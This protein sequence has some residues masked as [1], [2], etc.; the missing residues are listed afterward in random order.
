[1]ANHPIRVLLV[2]DDEDEY[3]MARNLLSEVDTESYDVSWAADYDTGLETAERNEHDVL[4]IDY[5]LGEHNGLEL[6]RDALRIG[7]R[8]PMILLTG[9]GD[10]RVDV[11]AMRAG[12]DDYLVKDSIDSLQLERAIRYALERSR[13]EHER[14]LLEQ[15]LHHSQKMD[16]IGQL[17]GGIAH[18]FNNLLT[19]IIGYTQLGRNMVAPGTSLQTHFQ[20]IQ[21]AAQLAAD[22]TRQLLAF[23]RRQMVEQKEL[24]LND[25]I[26]DTHKMLRR[27]I[28]ENVELATV[29]EPGL[30]RVIADAGLVEQVLVNIAINARDAMPGGGKLTIETRNVYLDHEY[31]A[32]HTNV[33]PGDY[34]MLAISDTGTGMTDEV[35]AR[36]F[37]PFF[38]TKGPGEGTGL[39]LSTCYGIV[40]QNGGHISVHSELGRGTTFK[41]Y[42]PR[43]VGG[44]SVKA[45]DA[46]VG[47]LPKGIENVLLVE[48]EET[49]RRMV[50]KVLRQQGYTVVEAENGSDALRLVD[51]A[52]DQGIDLL[53]TDMVMPLMGGRELASRLMADRTVTKVI[54][55]S[56]YTDAGIGQDGTLEPGGDFMPKPFTLD[57]LAHKVRE[58]LDT[59]I[60]VRY[61]H[62]EAGK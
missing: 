35:R 62:P 23:S 28:G 61:G 51:E 31:A 25:L 58:V 7:C 9:H 60:T 50:A 59:D 6:L 56:G 13:A 40:K 54:Y 18:D 42:L 26:I 53:L 47:L 45:D 29:A 34:V 48:D 19:A 16:A 10:R 46:N 38:T 15:Q 43:V 8:A 57:S 32:K 52:P 12:A 37:D 49:L 41:M 30:G 20:E 36:I 11:E 55:T 33:A 17:A 5:Q 39:G 22:L 3:L 4:L 1:M 27:L 2:D 24:S 21:K 14:S 44:D